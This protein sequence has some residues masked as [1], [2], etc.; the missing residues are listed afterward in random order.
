M[1]GDPLVFS[2]TE[3]S[4]PSNARCL[5]FFAIVERHAAS[6][7]RREAK[8]KGKCGLR[9]GYHFQMRVYVNAGVAQIQRDCFNFMMLYLT[10]SQ[11]K[12]T[13]SKLT[14]K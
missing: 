7:F 3:T 5:F 4:A 11:K 2:G 10:T 1:W 14:K 12:K 13:T 9:F 8:K 6:R